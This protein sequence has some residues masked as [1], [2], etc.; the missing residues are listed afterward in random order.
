VANVS[1]DTG[2]FESCDAVYESKKITSTSIM[3]AE[4]IAAPD[5]EQEKD[6]T[7]HGI[8]RGALGAVHR[9]GVVAAEIGER[10][11]RSPAHLEQRTVER[12]EFVAR[13]AQI[14]VRNEPEYANGEPTGLMVVEVAADDYPAFQDGARGQLDIYERNVRGVASLAAVSEKIAI[15]PVVCNLFALRAW[16]LQNKRPAFTISVDVNSGSYDGM[17]RMVVAGTNLMLGVKVCKQGT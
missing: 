17:R 1:R 6:C 4:S 7:Q 16:D 11:W 13:T 10:E 15:A 5:V 12:I 8:L 2:T 14:N 9:I 3:R